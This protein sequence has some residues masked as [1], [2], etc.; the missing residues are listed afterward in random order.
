[1]FYIDKEKKKEIIIN[2]TKKAIY[3]IVQVLGFT[4]NL[5]DSQ[6]LTFIQDLIS[7]ME[8]DLKKGD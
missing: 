5:T 4:Y 3:R 6:A 2:E 1:M 8:Q 7:V